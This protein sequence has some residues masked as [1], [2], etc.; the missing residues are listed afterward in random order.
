MKNCKTVADN[1]KIKLAGIPRMAHLP[2]NT[3]TDV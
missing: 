2:G 3:N 1:S